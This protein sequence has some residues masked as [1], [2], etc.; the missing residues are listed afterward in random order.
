MGI[1]STEIAVSI[2]AAGD[3]S[4]YPPLAEF[5]IASLIFIVIIVVTVGIGK[6]VAWAKSNQVPPMIEHLLSGAHQGLFMIDILVYGC[7]VVFKAY[8]LIR[9]LTTWDR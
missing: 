2:S 5:L 8:E 1:V 4:W 6:V 7:Y 9:L 3:Q